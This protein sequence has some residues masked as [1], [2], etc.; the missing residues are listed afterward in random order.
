MTENEFW[1]TLK[2][3]NGFRIDEQGY[4][5]KTNEDH[6][7]CPVTAVCL[8]TT[9]KLFE[10][11]NDWKKAAEELQLDLRFAELITEIADYTPNEIKKIL[12]ESFQKCNP[13]VPTWRQSIHYRRYIGLRKKLRKTLKL[14]EAK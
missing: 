13:P 2:K 3:I 14:E 1:K 8:E 5:I 10:D 11:T 12:W 6:C 9:G 7:L 4:I